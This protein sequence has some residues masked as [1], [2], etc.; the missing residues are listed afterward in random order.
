[1]MNFGRGVNGVHSMGWPGNFCCS[2]KVFPIRPHRDSD[3]ENSRA[4]AGS[5]LKP[6]V[7]NRFLWRIGHERL[8]TVKDWLTHA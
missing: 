7:F 6:E 2:A 3:A 1:M 8:A 5:P 4:Q